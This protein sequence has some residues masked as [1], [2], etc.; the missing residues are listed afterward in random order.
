[1]GSWASARIF[2]STAARI[3]ADLVLRSFQIVDGTDPQRD[4]WDLQFRAPGEHVVEL[5]GAEIIGRARIDEAMLTRIPPI[6][7]ENNPDVTR[8]RL[9]RGFDAAVAVRRANRGGVSLVGSRRLGANQGE[10]AEVALQLNTIPWS[11]A[12]RG[13][14]SWVDWARA[15]LG[16][17]QG[18]KTM[19]ATWRQG[20]ARAAASLTEMGKGPAN[21]ELDERR[22]RLP[23]YCPGPD[24][25]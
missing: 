9:A 3:L 24:G 19:T 22:P 12:V 25:V 2:V 15:I 6:A 8:R 4:R 21:L 10:R 11:E 5:L 1:M 18:A 23:A 16:E 17:A 14:K 7:V 20:W 13:S